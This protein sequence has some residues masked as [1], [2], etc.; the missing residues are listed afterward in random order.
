MGWYMDNR[1]SSAFGLG[2]FNIVAVFGLGIINIVATRVS[3]MKRVLLKQG[4]KELT[5]VPDNL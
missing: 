4:V 2:I 5:M 3:L 1:E